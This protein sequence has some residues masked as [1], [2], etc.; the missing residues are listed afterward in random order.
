MLDKTRL[1]LVLFCYIDLI[2]HQIHEKFNWFSDLHATGHNMKRK[3]NASKEN[4]SKEQSKTDKNVKNCGIHV[5]KDEASFRDKLLT[6]Y[7]ANCRTLPWRTVAKHEQDP[8]VRGY[9][10]WVSEVMLQQTQVATVIQ[11]Y[12]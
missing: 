1:I 8:D 7:D 6:W 3:R 2:F 10:V 5:I 11:Y 4:H 12:K 9:Q